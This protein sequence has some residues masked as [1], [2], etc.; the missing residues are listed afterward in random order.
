MKICLLNLDTYKKDYYEINLDN[1]ITEYEKI[2]YILKKEFA[3]KVVLNTKPF[4]DFFMGTVF[5]KEKKEVYSFIVAFDSGVL[6]V[7][8]LLLKHNQLEM[9]E[10]EENIIVYRIIDKSLFSIDLLKDI[11]F[12]LSFK[13]LTEMN[14]RKVSIFEFKERL[15]KKMEE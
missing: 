6:P 11:S 7:R 8:G 10:N 9:I 13:T 15:D 3:Y 2:E 1:L 14:N 5:Y 4:D 12:F